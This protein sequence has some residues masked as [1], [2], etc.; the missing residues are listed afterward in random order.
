MSENGTRTFKEQ[1]IEYYEQMFERDVH[2]ALYDIRVQVEAQKR[3][4][5]ETRKTEK[6]GV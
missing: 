3:Y 1:Q 4:L 5:E 2:K 6:E